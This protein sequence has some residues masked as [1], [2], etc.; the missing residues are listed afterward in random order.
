ML[1][2][3]FQLDP[4]RNGSHRGFYR[5]GPRALS[6]VP[7]LLWAPHTQQAPGALSLR[8]IHLLSRTGCWRFNELIAHSTVRRV[9]I[10]AG[11]RAEGSVLLRLRGCDLISSHQSP[12]PGRSSAHLFHGRSSC[13]PQSH[14]LLSPELTSIHFSGRDPNLVFLELAAICPPHTLV[15]VGAF[16]PLS[17]SWAVGCSCLCPGWAAC[18]SVFPSGILTPSSSLPIHLHSLPAPLHLGLPALLA[19]P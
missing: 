10:V 12:V 3:G 13:L 18:L 9:P 15:L 4:E 11:G 8:H 17:H 5:G 6:R 14:A 19:L 16:K 2:Q 7:G 1:G